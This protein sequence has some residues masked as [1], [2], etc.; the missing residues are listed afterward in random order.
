[1][2]PMVGNF[3]IWRELLM[4]VLLH[5][6][7]L[8]EEQFL[9]LLPLLCQAEGFYTGVGYHAAYMADLISEQDDHLRRNNRIL[10]RKTGTDRFVC[11]R[12]RIRVGDTRTN[13]EN[14][15]PEGGNG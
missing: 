2:A 3:Q 4:R 11:V 8:T 1:M 6:E 12:D 7:A 9:L 10:F 5:C 14:P 15:I 13:E